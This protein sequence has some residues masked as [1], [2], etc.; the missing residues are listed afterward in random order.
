MSK[1]H[2]DMR[3]ASAFLQRLEQAEAATAEDDYELV[4]YVRLGDRIVG[5]HNAARAGTT[6]WWLPNPPLNFAHFAVNRDPR[7]RADVARRLRGEP[8][9]TKTPPAP[10]PGA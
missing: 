7:V 6:A 3:A 1:L 10:V 2:A 5:T 8:P 4:P 9:L